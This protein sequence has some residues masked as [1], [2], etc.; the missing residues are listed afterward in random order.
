MPTQEEFDRYF[1]EIL[2]DYDHLELDLYLHSEP[3]IHICDINAFGKFSI[4]ISDFVY[5]NN[6]LNLFRTKFNISDNTTIELMRNVII[7]LFGLP[8]NAKIW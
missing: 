1:L 4:G 5:T 8:Y 6:I 3:W 7:N 2:S